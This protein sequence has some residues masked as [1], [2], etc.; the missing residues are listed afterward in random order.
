MDFGNR[1]QWNLYVKSGRN[2][3]YTKNLLVLAVIWANKM[4][5]EIY[6]NKKDLKD[7]WYKAAIDSNNIKLKYTW[8]SIRLSAK[9][10]FDCWKF[11]EELALCM[12]E[13]FYGKEEVGKNHLA[14]TIINDVFKLVQTCQLHAD[15]ATSKIDSLQLP[16]V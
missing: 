6:K 13:F 11:G 5:E 9:I 2:E 8:Y 1:D 16:K 4:E 10:L 3:D 7:V 14:N 15:I 12:D